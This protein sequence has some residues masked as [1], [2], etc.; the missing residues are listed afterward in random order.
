MKL[1]YCSLLAMPRVHTR[2]VDWAKAG[3]LAKTRV[4]AL[5]KET[6]S[7]MRI[8][9]TPFLKQLVRLVPQQG[10]GKDFTL[11]SKSRLS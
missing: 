2:S 8:D 11:V 4:M 1:L 3:A 10:R 7:D 9:T 5:A 6:R